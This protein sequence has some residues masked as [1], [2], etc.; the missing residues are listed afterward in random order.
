MSYILEA[1]K[2]LEQKRQLEEA[3]NLLTLQGSI[4]Q[5]SKKRPVWPYIT[6]GFLFLNCAIVLLLFWVAPW[7]TTRQSPSS[8]NREI[9]KE[10][11]SLPPVA[12][13][14]K[15]GDVIGRTKRDTRPPG[16][17]PAKGPRESSP[18]KPAPAKPVKPALPGNVVARPVPKTTKPAPPGDRAVSIGGLP[19]EVKSKLPELKMTV[20]SYDERSQAS[21][22]V[23]NNKTA[24]V[25]QLIKGDVKV[26]QITQRGVILSFQGHKFM[27]AI[28]ENP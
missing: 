4:A 13:S 16:S 18:S 24:R 6:A 10:I 26:E 5:V 17:A 7:K 1:L 14:E 23:I 2:K 8:Q 22:V 15:K 12:V 25:G 11:A 28:N 27:L 9:R 3:P 19:E 20:H 21:F